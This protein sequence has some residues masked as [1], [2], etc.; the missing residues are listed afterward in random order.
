MISDLLALGAQVL[1]PIVMNVKKEITEVKTEIETE[2]VVG[3]LD[4]GGVKMKRL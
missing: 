4:T 2:V 1:E 3:D